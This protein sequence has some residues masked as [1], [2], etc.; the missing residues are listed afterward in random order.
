MNKK[1]VLVLF[2]GCS[3][4]HEVS[5]VSAFS[6][7][8]NMP[9]EKYNVIPV[10]ITR[11][12]KWLL[13]D[14]SIDNLRNVPWEKFG[15]PAI[16]SADRVNRGL[17]RIVGDKVKYIPVDVV[18]PVLH[19]ANGE[20]GTVQ[21]LFELSGLRYVG[22]GVLASAVCM[23]K[24]FTK[25]LAAHLGLK[26]AD[27][28]SQTLRDSADASSF[29]EKVESKIGYP[30]FVKPAN[31][32][33]S[34]GISKASSKEDLVE[35]IEVAFQIDNKILVEKAV[36]GR[37]LECAVLGAGFD[38]Q[39]S[40][41]GEIKAAGEFYDY[42]SKYNNA[43]SETVVPAG[44]PEDAAE[45]I[46]RQSVLIF[47]AVGGKGLA[48]VDF[49]LEEGT[50]AVIFNELNTMPGFTPISMYSKLWRECGISW[51]ELIDKLIEIALK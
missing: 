10:Y 29:I 19:G 42:D 1:N 37:E 20:D 13:Y 47:G 35:A 41:V 24:S 32:G 40:V 39:A 12:G 49:F 38:A 33:S 7:I 4:E 22:C 44:I 31:A 14:G 45:E 3:P 21:G 5:K 36:V 46:R 2:G 27:Y 9:E 16:L 48:R 30:C 43:K 18:F 25:I 26:Q 28:L 51:S 34:V 6:V 50:N 17:L 23:D 15:T 8:A 11:E